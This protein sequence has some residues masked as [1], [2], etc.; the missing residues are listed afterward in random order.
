MSVYLGRY[1]LRG[2]EQN[3]PACLIHYSLPLH[4][5][6]HMLV[7]I[8]SYVFVYMHVHCC[9]YEFHITRMSFEHTQA[10]VSVQHVCLA[11]LALR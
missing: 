10:F 6:A 11:V 8:R 2:S 9:V 3:Y 5:V 4:T 7:R 1:A